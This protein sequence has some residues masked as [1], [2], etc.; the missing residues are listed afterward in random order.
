MLSIAHGTTGALIATKI[1]N[2]FISIPL[3]LLSHYLEDYIPH[4]DVGQ[5]LTKQVKSKKVAFFQELATDL[6]ASIIIVYL[7]FQAGQSEFNTYAWFGWFTG[8]LPDFLEFPYLF[9]NWRFFPFK[10]QAAFHKKFHR[11]TTNKLKGLLPQ[12]AV[13]LASLL[14]R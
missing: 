3:I 7:F 2:P 13:I 10:Q 9:L 6:P 4:W 5:G 11:S 14:L 8:L 1:H 12:A